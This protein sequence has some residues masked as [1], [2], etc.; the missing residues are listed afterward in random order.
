MVRL[1]PPPRG[2]LWLGLGALLASACA[3]GAGGSGDA[4]RGGA[5][6]RGGAAGGGAAG[7]GQEAG[8]ESA[9]DAPVDAPVDAPADAAADAPVDAPSSEPPSL[10]EKIAPDLPSFDLPPK[11]EPAPDTPPEV[12]PDLTDDLPKAEGGTCYG[13][14]YATAFEDTTDEGWSH[15]P[16]TV[17]SPGEDPWMRGAVTG[18]PMCHSGAKC[19]TVSPL[20][21]GSYKACTSAFLLSPQIDLSPCGTGADGGAAD[22]GAATVELVFWQWW[23]VEPYSVDPMGTGGGPWWDGALLQISGDDGATWKEVTPSVPYVGVLNPGTMGCP[24]TYAPATTGKMGWSGDTGG[25]AWWPVSVAIPPALRTATFRVRFVFAS[26]PL[27]DDRGWF[28][29]DV[30]VQAY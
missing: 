21:G 28:V 7:G 8:P 24:P 19:W 23:K 22:A 2:W 16:T 27:G 11:P 30:H 13:T 4:G 3:R 9:A 20:A 18:A 12:P 1:A 5:G 17:A 26:D 14:Y 25:D 15:Y 10:P 6:G 29:D